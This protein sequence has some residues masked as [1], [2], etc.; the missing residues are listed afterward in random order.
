M[1]TEKKLTKMQKYAMLLKETVVQENPVYKELIEHEMELLEKKNSTKSAEPTKA[2]KANAELAQ[3]IYNGMVENR[4]YKCAE[5]AKVI[6]E[7]EGMSTQKISPIMRN[8]EG[9]LFEKVIDKRAT[10][11]KKIMVESETDED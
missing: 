1:A 5:I 9:V 4:L 2:Q 10:C 7:C 8:G 11:Y 6:P 3:A